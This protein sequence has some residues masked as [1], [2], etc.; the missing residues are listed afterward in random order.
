MR[1]EP[2]M[3][4]GIAGPIVLDVNA[5]T[6]KHSVTVGGHPASGTRRGNY[7]LPTADGQTI[8][9]K[10][11]SNIFDPHPTL[12]IAG[13]TH[14][15]GPSQPIALRV[16]MVLPLLLVIGGLIGGVIGALGIGVNLGIA[17]G[18]QSTA[19][20]ALL[21]IVVLALTVVAYVAVAAAFL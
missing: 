6:G 5:I 2:L 18:Q 14:R 15:T 8:P 7:T 3:I 10:L 21:M 4:A 1:T 13:V 19:V 17:R 20:K 12:E 11:R 16:L 9:A